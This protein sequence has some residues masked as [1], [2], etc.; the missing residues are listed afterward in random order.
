MMIDPAILSVAFPHGRMLNYWSK[1]S[2]FVNPILRF[3]MYSSG[4]IPVDRKSKDRQVLFKG[5]FEALAKGQAVAL[6]PEGTS[7]TEPRIMQVK[8]GAAWASLEYARWR[9]DHP[10]AAPDQDVIIVPASIV[11]TDK[12]KYRSNVILEFGRPIT[13]ESF[14]EQFFS[15]VDGAQRA[16][17]KRLTRAIESELVEATINAPDWGT[18][19]TAR[20]ARDL[21]WE[22]G[23]AIK[24]DDFVAISQT[25]VDI[26]STPDATSNLNSVKH[27]LLEYYSL[28]QSSHLTNSVLSSLPLPRTLDPNTPTTVPSRLFTMLI[29]IR[30]SISAFLGL[31][32]FLFP[33]IVHMPV[34]IMG[35]L[36]ARLAEDEQE[37]QAQNKVV[38]GLLSLLLI[39]PAAFFF[40]WALLWYTPIGALLA[41]ATVYLFAIYHIKTIDANY[42]R[43]KRL[44]AAWRILVGVWAP[45]QWDLSLA[46]LSQ[47][48]T[49]ETPPDNPWIDRQKTQTLSSNFNNL[50][51]TGPPVRMPSTTAHATEPPVKP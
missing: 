44:I 1:A 13:M 39:Y 19:Y 51:T 30:D 42:E 22:G 47:Y 12:T 15:D 26:F 38:F 36:G 7:Y 17:V 33:L 31:P 6:F 11:Y 32:F 14:K 21:L 45:K 34:Y 2:L 8:D 24:L 20:M 16:A 23:K 3:I 25:L 40:L 9:K 43:A 28:L 41:A 5:S 29:L 27:H 4:N 35:R 48:T 10:R 18:L 50:P 37:T 46:A 49:P